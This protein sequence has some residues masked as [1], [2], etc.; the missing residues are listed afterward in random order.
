MVLVLTMLVIII[1]VLILCYIFARL[2]LGINRSATCLNGKTAVITGA[3]SGISFYK[4]FQ[5]KSK[6]ILGLGYQTALNLASRGCRIIMADIADMEDSKMNIIKYTNNSNVITKKLD[7]S[8]LQS[9]RDFAA[10]IVKT[11]ERLDILINNAGIGAAT[12]NRTKDGLHPLMQ[13]NYFG[14]FLLTHLLVGE[15]LR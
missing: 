13:I 10:D 2:S 6:Q 3:N 5:K 8:S 4:S 15:F 9:V 11:E 7:L 14:H 12:V 1:S